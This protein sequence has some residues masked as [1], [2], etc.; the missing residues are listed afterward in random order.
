MKKIVSIQLVLAFAY[1][2]VASSVVLADTETSALSTEHF[3]ATVALT[4]DYAFRGTTSTASDAA[5]QG[6]IDWSYKGFFAGVWGSNTA[7]NAGSTLEIDYYFGW[8]G[9][10]HGVELRLMPLWYT[11]PGQD[12]VDDTSFELNTQAAYR[13]TELPGSPRLALG[14]SW[15]PEYFD[16][17]DRAYYVRPVIDFALPHDVQLSVGYGYQD[18]GDR[19]RLL[20]DDYTHFDV[21]VS[22]SWLGFTLAVAYHHNMDVKKLGKG[23]A[24]DKEWIFTMSRG[25]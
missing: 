19:N 1:S 25:F 23:F 2:T 24:L 16:G 3:S 21:G 7:E 14:I 5:L 12:T 15:S 9:N 17:G 22:R 6:S 8:V 18:I 4:T 11:F 13:F 10:L 20:A